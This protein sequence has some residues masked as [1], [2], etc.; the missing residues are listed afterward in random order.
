MAEFDYAAKSP[1]MAWRT[2]GLVGAQRAAPLPTGDAQAAR[3]NL[4]ELS[5]ALIK[6]LPSAL[7][8]MSRIRLPCPSSR[9]RVAPLAASSR[10]IGKLLAA[11]QAAAEGYAAR[12]RDD[13]SVRAKATAE[14]T[15]LAA[16]S[17]IGT[18]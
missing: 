11:G 7:N 1:K 8:A 17:K 9:A 13:R 18:L 6:V 14:T 5:P 3:Q 2:S 4:I 10:K 12:D 15:S 16:A